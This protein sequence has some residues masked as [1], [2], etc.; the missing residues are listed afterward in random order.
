[1]AL[2]AR[3]LDIMLQF[4]IEAIALCAF[5]GIGIMLGVGVA[6]MTARIADWPILIAPQVML[7]A[8]AAAATTG[9]LFGFLP[10]RRS[11]A[12]PD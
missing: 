7:L 1:M 9:I 12:Q 11:V 5:R 8:I 10:A 4:L 6:S 3:R 2:G